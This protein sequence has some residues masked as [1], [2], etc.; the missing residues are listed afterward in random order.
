MEV[1]IAVF[2]VSR[3]AAV[4]V[5]TSDDFTVGIPP[6][7]SGGF[8]AVAGTDHRARVT[9]SVHDA[10]DRMINESAAARPVSTSPEMNRF[11]VVL[12]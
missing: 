9:F 11:W 5:V 1:L 8:E 4:A 6:V 10:A 7:V 12:R 2:A 3:A